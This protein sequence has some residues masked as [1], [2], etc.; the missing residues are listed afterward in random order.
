M[1]ASGQLKEGEKYDVDFN[2]QFIETELYDAK[3]TYKKFS[4]YRPGVKERN[5]SSMITYGYDTAYCLKSHCG[6]RGCR[7]QK[8]C[9]SLNLSDNSVM[10][11]R[12]HARRRMLKG[13]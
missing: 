4:N 9:F 8:G 7:R 12:V 11:G 5:V 10:R 2:H 6:V 1:F 3:P 13:S